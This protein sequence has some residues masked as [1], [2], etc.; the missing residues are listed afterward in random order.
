LPNPS[1]E[2]Q[3][4]GIGKFN[5]PDRK[6]GKSG[7]IK[8]RIIMSNKILLG[9]V[10][11]DNT[12]KLNIASELK[13]FSTASITPDITGGH[14]AAHALGSEDL[15][16]LYEVS[17]AVNSTLILD[18]ILSIV[19]KKSIELLKAE[20]G[21][22]MLLDSDGKLQFKTAHNIKKQ[23]LD[24]SDLKVS[25]TIAEGVVKTGRSTYTSDALSDDRF[26][27]KQSVLQMNIR[28]AMCV[29]LKIKNQMIGVVYLDNS[30]KANIFLQSDLY[31]FELFADQAAL[32]IQN[33]QLYTELFNLQRFQEAILDK[34]PVA[35]IVVE[36]NGRLRS[37]NSAAVRL[38]E[39]A[40]SFDTNNPLLGENL[41]HLLPDGEREFWWENIGKSDVKT[42]EVESHK[43]KTGA[44]DIFI[45]LH[46]SPFDH[47][48]GD[49]SGRIIVAEDITEKVI[50]EQYLIMSE[51]MIAKGEMAASIGHELNN[52]LATISSNAQLLS[53]N[54]ANQQY[55]KVPPK[56]EAMVSNIDK[57]KRFTA[58]LMDFS[59]LE[60]RKVI[61]DIPRLV[62]DVVFFV[63]PQQKFKG[64]KIELDMASDLPKAEIDVGQ[65][66]QVLLNLLMNAADS[67]KDSETKDGRISISCRA[68]GDL[69]EI[70]V[71]DNG[72]GISEEVLLRIFEP[73]ITTKKT[74]HGLG[75]STSYRIISNHKGRLIGQN[76][77]NGGAV[78]TVE[79][80]L[81]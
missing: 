32:A 8:W 35:I 12:E 65:V 19:M 68:K 80:P 48:E 34:T 17:R 30:S 25:T 39:K 57:M 74:G 43:L 18:E 26:C 40:Y 20:R 31:L 37:L 1:F 28:S 58:G 23:E 46:F 22:L 60:T 53:I 79:L 71:S 47:M 41:L 45:R 21:F 73:Y 16:V 67:I 64:I 59:N 42:I 49:L 66:H 29:P 11:Y 78:F 2:C 6:R 52:Y 69:M 56:V 63:K 51:K 38:F 62:D 33:A 3:Q 70:M 36:N 55:E 9:S 81:R 4:K 7:K 76:N 44:S 24:Q 72:P 50:L 14:G 13:K 5:C 27:S 77:P 61:C 10:R 15:Q 54:I 75:L